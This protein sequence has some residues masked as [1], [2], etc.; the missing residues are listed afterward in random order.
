[1]GLISLYDT[2]FLSLPSVKSSLKKRGQNHNFEYV[3]R[4]YKGE[5]V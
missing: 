3:T 5:N 2:F 4:P 1:M